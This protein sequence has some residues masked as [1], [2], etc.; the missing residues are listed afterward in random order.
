MY[1]RMYACACVRVCAC[2]LVCMCA[3]ARVCAC[4]H[5]RVYVCTGMYANYFVGEKVLCIVC[6]KHGDQQKNL[7]VCACIVYA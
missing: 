6:L 4:A 3:R 1:V 2:T 7:H 5:V